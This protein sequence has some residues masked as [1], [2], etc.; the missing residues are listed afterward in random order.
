MAVYSLFNQSGKIEELKPVTNLPL[1]TKVFNYG[2]GMNGTIGAIIQDADEYGNYKCVEICE[3]N[4][5]FFNL[6]KYARPHSKVFGI[7]VY[8]AD[9]LET[10]TPDLV[11]DC[12]KKA[13][14]WQKEKQERERLTILAD[15]KEREELPKL[16]PHLTPNPKGDDKITKANLIAEL[17]KHFPDTK[18]SVKKENYST[19]YV[20]WTNGATA[21]NVAKI[22]GKFEEYCTSYCGDFRDFN[23]SNFTRVFGGFKYVFE[24]RTQSEE[25]S[26]L[27]P[28][29][30]EV[31]N[32]PDFDTQ[33]ELHKIFCKTNI[34]QNA[35]NFD[36]IKTGIKCGSV[37]EFYTIS[38]D[39]PETQPKPQP[40]KNGSFELVEYS[41]RALAVFGDT[42]SIKEELKKLG[43]RFNAHLTHNGQKVAG[44]IFPRAKYEILT[45][46]IK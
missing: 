32:N 36:I 35:I 41:E 30:A 15:N 44:W 40:Q 28:K 34:P 6:D 2:Y 3:E 7:G 4:P 20:R 5:E 1:F 19:Y 26:A 37:S 12:I 18:F 10:F 45:A 38:F 31:L 16:Y 23:P 9:N 22:T 29:L 25:I 21:E 46:L 33:R 27:A 42:K 14:A 24:S 39:L 17:K 11:A 13:E 8:Y 43:G